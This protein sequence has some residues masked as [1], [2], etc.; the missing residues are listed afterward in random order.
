MSTIRKEHDTKIIVV[1]ASEKTIRVL[2][3]ESN[4]NG[5]DVRTRE[6]NLEFIASGE[7]TDAGL[8]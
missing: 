6:T 1:Q 2:V 4:S 3:V 5:R 8:L 7:E